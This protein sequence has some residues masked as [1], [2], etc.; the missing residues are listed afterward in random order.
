LSAG[1]ASVLAKA[2]R[3][4]LK[5]FPAGPFRLSC[6]WGILLTS[7]L[8]A[9]DNSQPASLYASTA[10][11]AL[12]SQARVGE[13]EEERGGLFLVFYFSA[14]LDRMASGEFFSTLIDAMSDLRDRLSALVFLS[15]L[16][17]VCEYLQPALIGRK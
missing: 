16:L 14:K 15:E 13:R 7:S 10:L 2:Q 12:E 1:S 11:S 5:R 8:H 17:P 9:A 3:K 4:G 6:R